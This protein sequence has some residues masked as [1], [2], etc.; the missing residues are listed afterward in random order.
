MLVLELGLLEL[1]HSRGHGNWQ[2]SDRGEAYKLRL[3]KA[4]GYRIENESID[5]VV[6]FLSVGLP[7]GIVRGLDCSTSLDREVPGKVLNPGD[8]KLD[9]LSFVELAAMRDNNYI[10]T[11]GRQF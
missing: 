8:Q 6:A 10:S 11:V 9:T 7:N 4:V 5:V 3:G 1:F 2:S